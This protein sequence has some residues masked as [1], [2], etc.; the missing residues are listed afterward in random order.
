MFIERLRIKSSVTRIKEDNGWRG[1]VIEQIGQEVKT[2][3]IVD[4]II[5][6]LKLIV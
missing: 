3:Y 6:E 5:M 4:K 1:V 2:E